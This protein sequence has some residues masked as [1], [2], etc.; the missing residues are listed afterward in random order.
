MI[1]S[2][3]GALER[4]RE[5]GSKNEKKRWLGGKGGAGVREVE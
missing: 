2:E 3:E 5:T 4:R 1:E